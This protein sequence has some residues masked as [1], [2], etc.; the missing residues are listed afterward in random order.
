MY[1]LKLKEERFNFMMYHNFNNA[2]LIYMA[3][4]IRE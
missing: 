2:K 1:Y 4:I 3:Q